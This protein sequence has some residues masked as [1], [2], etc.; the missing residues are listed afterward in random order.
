MFLIQ[1]LSPLVAAALVMASPAL[2]GQGRAEYSL[3]FSAS[4]TQRFHV[5]AD[6]PV[7]N[8]ELSMEQGVLMAPLPNGFADFIENLKAR[9]VAGRPV[10]LAH[11]GNGRW[12]LARPLKRVQLEYDVALKHQNVQWAVSGLFARGYSVEDAM[13]FFGY[14][15]FITGAPEFKL[16]AHVRISV[17]A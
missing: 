6:L 13:F 5:S 1:L 17:P 8:N 2:D 4:S 9:D 12:K 3:T 14:V 16:P 7:A 15:A 10:A 11:L